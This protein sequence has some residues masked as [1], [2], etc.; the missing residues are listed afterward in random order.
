MARILV[1]GGG[2]CGLAA[3]LMLARDGHDVTLLERDPAAGAGRPRWRRGTPGSAA[4]CPSSARRTGCSSAAARCSTTSCPTSRRRWSPARATSALTRSA[5]CRRRS[6]TGRRGPATSASSPLHVAP[7]VLEQVVARAADAQARP[8][9]SAAASGVAA[10]AHASA[11]AVIGVR[12]RRRGGADR[13][14]RRRRDGTRAPACRSCSDARRARARAPRMLEP[15]PAS[16]TT[17]A[18]TDGP[19]PEPRAPRL[20]AVGSFSIVT[21]RRRQ[22]HLV[23]HGRS[24]RPA[25]RPLKRLR[26]PAAFTALV[27]ACPR[28]AH[29]L[30]GRADHRRAADGAA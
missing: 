29:W 24:P 26:D 11:G 28:H 1:L 5:S 21:A 30:D 14:P 12:T 18:T 27:R 17:R 23:D 20:T 8:R 13:R 9:P 16:S 25:D 15:M 4:A 3:G 22:R 2:V 7:P 19:Q 10:L 6:R